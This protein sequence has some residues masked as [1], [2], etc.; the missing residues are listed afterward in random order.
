MD[1]WMSPPRKKTGF[2]PQEV[3]AEFMGTDVLIL[4]LCVDCGKE[5]YFE[6]RSLPGGAEHCE[7]CEECSGKLKEEV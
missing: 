5:H 6:P 1:E 3:A 4:Y 7:N 2:S